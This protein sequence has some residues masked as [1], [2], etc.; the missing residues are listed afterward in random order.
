MSPSALSSLLFPDPAEQAPV[1]QIRRESDVSLIMSLLMS[2]DNDCIERQKG[3]GGNVS[4]N[5]K[6][7]GKGRR[8]KIEGNRIDKLR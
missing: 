4:S 2:Q 7:K 6:E 3:C 1:S 8:R 5:V